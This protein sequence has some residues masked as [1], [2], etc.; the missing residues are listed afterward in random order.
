MLGPS[1][2]A[3]PSPDY[4]E[5]LPK[6]QTVSGSAVMV[7]E[8]RI[9]NSVQVVPFQN[10]VVP[11]VSGHASGYALLHGSI[12]QHQTPFAHGETRKN[13]KHV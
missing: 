10:A 3:S 2:P 4:F 6:T 12:N 8:R 7:L 5:P 1:Y 9:T 11:L 13:K